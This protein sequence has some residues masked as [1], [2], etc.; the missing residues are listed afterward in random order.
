MSFRDLPNKGMLNFSYFRDADPRRLAELNK[1]AVR[2]EQERD[3]QDRAPSSRAIT[4]DG[5][6]RERTL[7]GGEGGTQT[8]GDTALKHSESE[9]LNDPGIWEVSDSDESTGSPREEDG[10]YGRPDTSEQ[11]MARYLIE[12][13]P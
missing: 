9:I 4:G 6:T 3:R 8:R 7:S 10:G 11:E 2:A 12:R 1:L 5:R 13:A